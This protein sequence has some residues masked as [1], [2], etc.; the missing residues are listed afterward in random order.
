MALPYTLGRAAGIRRI[1]KF[2]PAAA[3]DRAMRYRWL[4]L[5][6]ISFT[7]KP[8]Y[9]DPG[10][11]IPQVQGADMGKSPHRG[12]GSIVSRGR[13]RY[14]REGAQRA[15]EAGPEGQM[16]MERREVRGR[17]TQQKT[18]A[19]KNRD[20]GLRSAH[21]PYCPLLSLQKRGQRAG[22][23]KRAWSAC[24]TGPWA[25]LEAQAAATARPWAAAWRTGW[26]WQGAGQMKAPAGRGRYGQ[27]TVAGIRRLPSRD[28][29][30]GGAS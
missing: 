20:G 19:A 15:G 13:L 27:K 6:V 4:L 30:S 8:P 5:F 26:P 10:R 3:N 7:K 18:G 1:L 22:G 9:P 12:G 16:G 23:R 28:A 2:G 24:G 17:S 29:R 11:D 25:G 21:R 14:P